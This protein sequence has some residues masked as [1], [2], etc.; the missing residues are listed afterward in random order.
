[1]TFSQWLSIGIEKGFCTKPYCG[2]HDTPPLNTADGTA[3]EQGEDICFEAVR[4][5]SQGPQG[6]DAQN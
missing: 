4:I 5:N 2:N 1:M 6:P 3:L